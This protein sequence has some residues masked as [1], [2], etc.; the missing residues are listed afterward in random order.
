MRLLDW[1]S[2]IAHEIV[3]VIKKD[4][5]KSIISN[6]RLKIESLCTCRKRHLTTSHCLKI[7]KKVAFEIL[8]FGI[9]QQFLSY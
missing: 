6:N 7:T 2:N 8:N 3:F 1:F 4:F 9:F 5:G